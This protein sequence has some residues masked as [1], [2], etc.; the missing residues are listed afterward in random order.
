MRNFQQLVQNF[1]FRNFSSDSYVVDS[2]GR[3]TGEKQSTYTAIS[4]AEGSVTS[5][6]GIVEQM[7]FGSLDGYD[8]VITTT[9]DYGVNETSQI[10]LEAPTTGPHDFEV[11]R[12]SKSP[13]FVVIAVKKVKVK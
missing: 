5:N 13:N 7:T 12:I 9:K 1:S 11:Y 10:W 8:R 4:E 2:Q 6:K 3:R